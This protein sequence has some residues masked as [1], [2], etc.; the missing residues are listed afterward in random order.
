MTPNREK[1]YYKSISRIKNLRQSTVILIFGVTFD[2][3][4]Y[5]L[6][7]TAKNILSQ[8]LNI[9]RHGGKLSISS[10]CYVRIFHTKVFC[11]AFLLLKFGFVFFWRKN[12]GAKA[13]RK[14]SMK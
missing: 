13:A 9:Q 4:K 6:N 14:M 5:C 10:T 1:N 12:I 7:P 11:A 8:K 3:F 2:L